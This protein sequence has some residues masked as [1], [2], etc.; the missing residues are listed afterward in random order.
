MLDKLK[1]S[2][3]QSRENKGS[4]CLLSSQ[5]NTENHVHGLRLGLSYLANDPYLVSYSEQ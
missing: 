2:A 4:A 1:S 3:L 5:F